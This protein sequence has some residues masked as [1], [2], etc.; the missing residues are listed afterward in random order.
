MAVKNYHLDPQKYPRIRRKIILTYSVLALVALLIFYIYLREALFAQVWILIP[1][2]LLLFA[3]AGWFAIHQRRKYWYE[4][5]LQ[6][7]DQYLIRSVPNTPD[8]RVRFTDITDYREVRQ[9][10]ILST[11]VSEN[12]ML[13]PKALRDQ[14]YQAVKAEITRRTTKQRG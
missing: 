2:I 6:F 4:F 12:A 3:A 13:I 10:L 14:D 1:F 7:T 9:G 11:P 8:M 5:E